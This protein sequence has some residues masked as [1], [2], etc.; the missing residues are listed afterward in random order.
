MW[1]PLTNG[2]HTTC[3]IIWLKRMYYAKDIG[4]NVTVKPEILDE[5]LP[6]VQASAAGVQPDG[7]DVNDV[8]VGVETAPMVNLRP[9]DDVEEDD[10]VPEVCTLSGCVVRAQS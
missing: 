7:D 9:L 5:V 1:N 10:G 3:D 6:V 8:S 2:V 4:F